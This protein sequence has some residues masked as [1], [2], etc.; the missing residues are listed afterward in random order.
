MIVL[1]HLTLFFAFPPP[2]KTAATRRGTAAAFVQELWDAELPSGKFRYYGAM[3]YFLGL[4]QV[5]WM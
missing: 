4:L 2:M 1:L 5:R 3:L